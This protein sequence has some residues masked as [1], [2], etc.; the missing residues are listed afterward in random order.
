MAFLC[1][2]KVDRDHAIIDHVFNN[3]FAE[4]LNTIVRREY[5]KICPECLGIDDGLY[6]HLCTYTTGE[7]I[8]GFGGTVLRQENNY[9]GLETW[10][11]FIDT[12]FRMKL[13]QK[14]YRLWL[15]DFISLEWQ[16]SVNK[17]E[18]ARIMDQ[19]YPGTFN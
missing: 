7:I 16:V 4:T 5:K 11:R 6:H 1:F 13:N 19:K 3:L 14:A 2:S 17:M 12:V 9:E 18:I 10:K 15:M 8:R